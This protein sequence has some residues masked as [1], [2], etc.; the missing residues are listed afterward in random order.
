MRKSVAKIMFY[1][2]TF[3]KTLHVKTFI[4]EYMQSNQYVSI[5]ETTGLTN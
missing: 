2:K 5:E 4:G 1:I 3:I